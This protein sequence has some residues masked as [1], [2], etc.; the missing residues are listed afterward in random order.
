MYQQ[1]LLELSG[2]YQAYGVLDVMPSI[3]IDGRTASSADGYLLLTIHIILSD[4]QAL[5]TSLGVLYLPPLHDASS[6]AWK[7]CEGL[8]MVG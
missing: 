1:R 8:A 4:W 5:D 2:L 7:V 3:M 6:L